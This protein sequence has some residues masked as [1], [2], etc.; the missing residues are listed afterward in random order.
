MLDLGPGNGSQLE[1]FNPEGV[2]AIYGAEPSA[3]LHGPLREAVKAKGLGEKYHIISCGAEKA[4]LVP[5]LKDIGLLD[6]GQSG[7]FDTI[8]C[9]KVLCSV[10]NQEDTVAGLFELLKPGGTLVMCEHIRNRWETPK[11]SAI[12]RAIQITFTF[13]GWPFFLGGCHLNRNTAQVVEAAAKKD[14]GWQSADI[15]YVVSW[16]SIPFA[17]GQFVKK[18]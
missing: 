13:L 7:V 15:D 17:I 2:M 10:P 18:L 4:S 11:G 5:A 3:A 1:Y 8:V 16:G 12:S 6:D 14:G 9:S